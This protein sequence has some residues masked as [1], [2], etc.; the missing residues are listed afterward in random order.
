LI[1]ALVMLVPFSGETP[2]DAG[3]PYLTAAPEAAFAL[4]G[5]RRDPRFAEPVDLVIETQAQWQAHMEAARK[6]PFLFDG[7]VIG[8]VL[9]E[10]ARAP[11]AGPATARADRESMAADRKGEVVPSGVPCAR[12]L[13]SSQ[14]DYGVHLACRGREPDSYFVKMPSSAPQQ[15]TREEEARSRL[16]LLTEQPAPEYAEAGYYSILANGPSPIA[17]VM[18]DGGSLKIDFNSAISNL[19]IDQISRGSAFLD[20][21]LATSLSAD[22]EVIA[23]EF[24][25]NGDCEAFWSALGGT[26]C[27]TL[28]RAD[29][30]ERD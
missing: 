18:L 19:G 20:Q 16:L 22:D 13:G 8:V 17:S 26:G 11:D 28:T 6:S 24:T 23:V 27:H 5:A 7:M 9:P 2:Q 12:D 29:L 10:S 14:T 15:G 21:V 1:A 30:Q 3:D 4:A 25:L